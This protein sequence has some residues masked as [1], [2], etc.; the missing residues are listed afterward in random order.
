MYILYVP[1]YFLISQRGDGEA[2]V[3][4]FFKVCQAQSKW[5]D[6]KSI[7]KKNRLQVHSMYIMHILDY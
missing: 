2:T 4:N 7:L 5:Y 6:V 3:V 1:E